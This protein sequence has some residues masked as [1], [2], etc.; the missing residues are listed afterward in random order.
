[1]HHFTN[2][3]RA[4][5]LPHFQTTIHLGHRRKLK[6]VLHTFQ[7]P[8][9]FLRWQIDEFAPKPESQ[10]QV[11]LFQGNHISPSLKLLPKKTKTV[12][13]CWRLAAALV[14]FGFVCNRM[15][16]VPA[17]NDLACFANMYQL[18]MDC[19]LAYVQYWCIFFQW[20]S[21]F[22]AAFIQVCPWRRRAQDARDAQDAS[23]QYRVI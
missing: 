11:T 14:A 17:A 13:F 6:L 18:H 4:E 5:K 21:Y 12:D 7:I 20:T 2:T 1:M 9:G 3:N 8:A 19:F 15:G 10:N 22:N 16:G 23:G